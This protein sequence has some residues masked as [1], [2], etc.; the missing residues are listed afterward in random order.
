MIAFELTTNW[1]L[2]TVSLD[3]PDDQTTV[4]IHYEGESLAIQAVKRWL[5]YQGGAFGHLIGNAT[6]PIDLHACMVLNIDSAFQPRF[7]EGSIPQAYE[8]DIPDGA[9]S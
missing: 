8:L 1:G 3:A 4:P 2:V 6:T 9:V 7:K 5:P